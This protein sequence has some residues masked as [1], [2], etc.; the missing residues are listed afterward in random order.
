MQSVALHFLWRATAPSTI[1]HTHAVHI[2]TNFWDQRNTSEMFN[3]DKNT[4]T[5][6]TCSQ[7]SWEGRGDMAMCDRGE[8]MHYSSVITFTCCQ[9]SWLNFWEEHVLANILSQINKIHRSTLKSVTWNHLGPNSSQTDYIYI[10]YHHWN[11]HLKSILM[12]V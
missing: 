4:F 2:I 12:I 1:T 10:F 5:H 8:P 3:L 9:Q 7:M 11:T 6:I